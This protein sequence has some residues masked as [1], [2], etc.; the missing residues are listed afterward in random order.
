MPRNNDPD[1]NSQSFSTL[2]HCLHAG[3]IPNRDS[4]S[5]SLKSPKQ[6]I[7]SSREALQ[8][9]EDIFKRPVKDHHMSV[10]TNHT[11]ASMRLELCM[12]SLHHLYSEPFLLLINLE[13]ELLHLRLVEPLIRTD[14]L[15]QRHNVLR[16]TL[17]LLLIILQN[18]QRPREQRPHR[19]PSHL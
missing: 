8:L 12:L 11:S 17:Q 2:E 5:S 1:L 10:T 18:F 13:H 6:G 7:E 15:A 19:T 14:C 16:Q 3:S 9:L 4:L